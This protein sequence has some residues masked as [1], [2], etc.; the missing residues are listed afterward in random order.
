M[1]NTTFNSIVVTL[2]VAG[3]LSTFGKKGQ[4]LRVDKVLVFRNAT[5][6]DGKGGSLLEHTDL[7]VEGNTI[8]AI[9]KGL[10]TNLAVVIDATHKTIMP[11]LSSTHVH[12]GTLKG[13]KTAV[14]NYTRENILSQ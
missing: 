4:G 11:A 7:R 12:V 3:I 1:R 2:F 10:D 13:T 6:I 5:I 8:T 14:L 9:G